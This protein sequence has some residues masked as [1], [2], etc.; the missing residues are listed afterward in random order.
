MG[1]KSANGDR[2]DCRID[3]TVS[4]IAAKVLLEP[5]CSVACSPQQ[6]VL[7][8]R[9]FRCIEPRD[10]AS[11]NLGQRIYA[12]V[13]QVHEGRLYASVLGYLMPDFTSQQEFRLYLPES[14]IKAREGDVGQIE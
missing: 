12:F 13:K 9:A 5:D 14:F 2:A 7:V 11:H 1:W 4:V 6:H 3:H 8:A 10:V